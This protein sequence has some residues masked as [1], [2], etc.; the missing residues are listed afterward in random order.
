MTKSLLEELPNIVKEGKRK[1]EQIMERLEGNYR[2]GLQ[3]RELVYPAKDVM[4]QDM[5]LAAQQAEAQKHTDGWMNR[6]IYGDNLLAMAA[7][8]AGDDQ[9]PSMRGKVDLIYIDPPFDSKADYRTK[10]ELPGTSVEQKPTA[11]EQ[12]AYG[13]TWV[14]G[15][16]SYLKMITPRIALIRELLSN[17][18]RFF[19]HIDWHVGHYV[20]IVI[21][22]IFGKDNFQNEIIWQRTDAHN[23]VVKKFG[24]IHDTILFYSKTD[25]FVFNA[26]AFTDGITDRGPLN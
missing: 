6:L 14:E 9:T 17:K 5:L 13:D 23:D 2:V 11:I 8:L 10:V 1:A 15:T 22:E 16:S 12:F 24:N 18:G 21:D 7:L 3:T 20:K 26:K 4:Q 19:F 25:S